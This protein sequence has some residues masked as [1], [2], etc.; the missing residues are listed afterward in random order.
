MPS[1]R[2]QKNP[3]LG[4][5]ARPAALSLQRMHV[6][7]Q[8]VDRH[9]PGAPA[10]QGQVVSVSAYR[11]AAEKHTQ[12]RGDLRRR[13][14]DGAALAPP[15]SGVLAGRKKID[16]ARTGGVLPFPADLAATKLGCAARMGDRAAAHHSRLAELT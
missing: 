3:S 14:Y 13:Q 12:E 5:G 7:F 9:Q 6:Y 4:R 16:H 10:Q 11:C 8:S 1:L 2:L 15:L